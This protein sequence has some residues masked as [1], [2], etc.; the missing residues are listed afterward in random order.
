MDDVGSVLAV[1]AGMSEGEREKLSDQL[2]ISGT[3][4]SMSEV[5][6]LMTN[7]QSMRKGGISVTTANESE[8]KQK[9]FESGGAKSCSIFEVSDEQW[10][11]RPPAKTR[12]WHR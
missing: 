1:L 11:H 4:A 3:S 10:K 5:A 9:T 12:G 7:A 6:E 8:Y 2:H